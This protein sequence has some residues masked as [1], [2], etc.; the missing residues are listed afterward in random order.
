[1]LNPYT[2]ALAVLYVS[3]ALAAFRF[4][5][6]NTLFPPGVFS[7]RELVLAHRP[8]CPQLKFCPWCRC[9]DSTTTL[10]SEPIL[11]RLSSFSRCQVSGL[12]VLVFMSLL[13]RIIY[14]PGVSGAIQRSRV[15]LILVRASVAFAAMSVQLIIQVRADSSISAS[16]IAV[17]MGATVLVPFFAVRWVRG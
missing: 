1:M 16:L 11:V 9:G 3:V 17:L 12:I 4:A 5:W 10:R 6:M 2:L 13:P 8:C 7:S 14:H 15:M